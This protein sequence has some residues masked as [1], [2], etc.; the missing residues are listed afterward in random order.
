MNFIQLSKNFEKGNEDYSGL[1]AKLYIVG[2]DLYKLYKN[3]YNSSIF[4]I[5]CL[6]AKQHLLKWTTLPSGIILENDKLKGVCIPYFKGYK[7]LFSLT[8]VCID[9]KIEILKILMRN[10]KEL[11]DNNI[12]PMDFNS[13]GVLV[14]DKDVKIIDLDTFTTKIIQNINKE[15]LKFVL[16]LYRN[17][18]LE[19]IYQDFEPVTVLP[20]LNAY[21][22]SKNVNKKI[23]FDIDNNISYHNLS[24][25]IESMKK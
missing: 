3:N 15:N 23:I 9:Y 19:L 12:Y 25:F 2:N 24:N 1:E 4:H 17:I 7:E 22:E 20:H 10:L 14:K 11:T 8:D 18:I 16:N 5:C 13:F 6:A 21:L